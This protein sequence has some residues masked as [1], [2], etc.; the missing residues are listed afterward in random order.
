MTG[1]IYTAAFWRATFERVIATAVQ[2][3]LALVIVDGFDVLNAD[4]RGIGLAV[5]T[6]ALLSLIKNVAANAITKTGP[7]LTNDER[8]TGAEDGRLP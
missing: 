6:A 1:S 2:A 8:V 7:S 4:W 3:L 5:A